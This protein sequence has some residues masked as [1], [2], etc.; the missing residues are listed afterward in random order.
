MGARERGVAQPYMSGRVRSCSSHRRE[1]L[2]D[3]WEMVQGEPDGR[4]ST[5]PHDRRWLSATVPGTV[6][7]VLRDAALWNFDSP[8]RA[9]DAEEWWFRRRFDAEPGAPGARLVLGLDGLA[10]LAEVWLN[11]KLLCQSDNMFLA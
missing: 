3:Q 11:G 2:A 7:S 4:S 1:L 5:A 6:A 9:F 8:S 10:T